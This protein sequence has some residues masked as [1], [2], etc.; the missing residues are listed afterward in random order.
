M[1]NALQTAS[2]LDAIRAAVVAGW[3][4]IPI[5]YG[6]PRTSILPA[7]YAVVLADAVE[8]SF[9]GVGASFSS[10]SQLNRFTI[11]GRFP[12]PSDPTMILDLER[13]T[14][15]NALIIQLQV[16]ST[17]AEIGIHPLVTS[18]SF[19]TLANPNEKVYDV[20]LTFSVTTLATHH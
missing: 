9:T 5:S 3:G 6:A 15:A 19:S 8:V 14:K 11:I 13:V 7:P 10:P 12:F 16:G 17:F 2:L 20:T 18:V 4:S 1:S